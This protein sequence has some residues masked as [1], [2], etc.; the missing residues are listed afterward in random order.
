[1]PLLIKPVVVVDLFAGIGGATQGFHNAGA[2]VALAIDS[3]DKAVLL[4]EHNFP[5]TECLIMELGGDIE[6]LAEIIRSY[7]PH[8]SWE[9]HFHLHGSP[10]CQ[11][12]SQA[13]AKSNPDQ[14]M[15]LVNWF[16]ELVDYMKPD[17]YSMENVIPAF[18]RIEG[19]PKFKI[20][21]ADL[22]VAQTRKRCIAGEGWTV[23][24]THDPGSWVGVSQVLPHLLKEAEEV[25]SDLWL[26]GQ[27][28]KG[29][30]SGAI[31]PSTGKRKWRDLAPIF[32]SIDEPSYTIMR[33]SR[34][35]LKDQDGEKV[36]HRTLTLEENLLIHGFPP[37][38]NLDLN[39]IT[40]KD[41]R[42]MVGNVVCPPVAEAII[43]GLYQ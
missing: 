29:S 11:A 34:R 2:K 23:E 19:R 39:G 41:L 21:S 5:H 18:K 36:L 7:L 35:V 14:G 31:D 43:R 37:T 25:G 10:P 32:R 38:Y 28:S 12:L 16:F 24:P 26:D 30:Y 17:S 33:T 40:K 3:W 42:V 1:M 22:G 13:N 15:E 8:E 4:H 6:E 27:R 20:N 9:Y